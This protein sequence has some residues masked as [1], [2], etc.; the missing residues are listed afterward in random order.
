MKR[1]ILKAVKYFSCFQYP[2]TFEE[3]RMF[4]PKKT[5]KKRFQ[6]EIDKLVEKKDLVKFDLHCSSALC[7]M[8]HE[9]RY[10]LGEYRIK[11]RNS[12]FRIQNSLKKIKKIQ[13]Y[14]KL[15]SFFPQIKLV[16]LSGTVAMMNAKENDDI[17]L[18][19][20]T[21]KNRLW[22]G[23]L[24]ALLIASILR[25]RRKSDDRKWKMEDRNL[26]IEDRKWKDKVCL[27]LFFDEKKMEVPDR[28][29]TEYVA[30]E[31][32][33]MKP[34]INRGDTYQRFLRANKWIYKVYPNAINP[35]FRIQNSELNLE[36]RIETL[37]SKSILNS[38]LLILNYLSNKIEVFLKNLQLKF[39]KRHQTNE[40]VTDSQLWF[41][42][43]DFEAKIKV[44]VLMT[45][46]KRA[47]KAPNMKIVQRGSPQNRIT[48]K[49]A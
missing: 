35:E 43:K 5:S 22:T 29:K 44:Q 1:A 33:Q 38:K 16:G 32:L 30:H 34:L 47:K 23:R 6:K 14:L 31:I 24:I 28:K 27:N 37:N 10:T 41:F 26:K 39:I 2:P 8:L 25:I 15:L 17:D 42:P 21:T 18:F 12:E 49:E 46:G 9:V 19:I 13:F 20:I 3:I 4:Y 48:K 36:S 7:Y 40:M 45:R 11:I